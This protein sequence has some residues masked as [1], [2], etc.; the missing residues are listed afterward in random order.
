MVAVA[1]YSLTQ[2]FYA[3]YLFL[4]P[5][6]TCIFKNKRENYVFLIIHSRKF[7]KTKIDTCDLSEVFIPKLIRYF[8]KNEK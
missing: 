8:N 7:V 2:I 6:I 5:K 3:E 1:G 4:E